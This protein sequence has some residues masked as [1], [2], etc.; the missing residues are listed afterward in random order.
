MD[1]G[2]CCCWQTAVQL[3]ISVP[4]ASGADRRLTPT[5]T[6]TCQQCTD[7]W[8]CHLCCC[9]LP[10][11]LANHAQGL[12]TAFGQACS[13]AGD[14]TSSSGL[15]CAVL[16]CAVLSHVSLGR[17]SL[18]RSLWEHAHSAAAAQPVFASLRRYVALCHIQAQR[19]VAASMAALAAS[20][21]A[22]GGATTIQQYPEILVPFLLQVALQA[23]L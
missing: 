7:C 8:C 18:H 15:C 23:E 1:M 9:G 16:C 11:S 2:S 6:D 10:A 21:A 20:P 14:S 3:Q 19:R 13:T 22:G 12:I 5:M 17:H 4:Q